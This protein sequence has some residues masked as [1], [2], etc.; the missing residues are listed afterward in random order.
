MKTNLI[1][2]LLIMLGSC[3]HNVYVKNESQKTGG[4]EPVEIAVDN[5]VYKLPQASA[6]R[7][8]GNYSNNVAIGMNANGDITYFPA[9]TDITADSKPIDLGNGWWLNRQGIGENAIFT[10]Y[11]FAE[12]AAL[13]QVPSIA[14]LKNSVIPGAHVT[15][16][17]ELPMTPGDALKNISDL[18]EYVKN[19]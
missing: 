3:S 14:Q 16:M 9:P 7:M 12:Y 15:Q 1:W 19:L 13:P 17:V 6:F 5:K 8:S 10:K 2:G 18:K 4:Y 11:T